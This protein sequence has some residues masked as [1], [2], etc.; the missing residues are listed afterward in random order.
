MIE[1]GVI[2][3]FSNSN[4]LNRQCLRTRFICAFTK[5]QACWVLL[6]I[7]EIYFR[8]SPDRPCLSIEAPNQGSKITVMSGYIHV[9]IVVVVFIRRL[10]S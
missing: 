9:L 6:L 10:V 4:K 8:G 3:N 5:F 2:G 1:P 7:S